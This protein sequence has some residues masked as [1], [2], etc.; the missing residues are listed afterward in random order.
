[1]TAGA[2][3]DGKDWSFDTL[4]RIYDAVEVVARDELAL[5]TFPNQIEVITAEQMLDAY[6]S[7]GMPLLYGI[8]LS[9]SV[10]PSMK[11][12]IAPASRALPMKSLST[13]TPASA[14]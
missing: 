12:S 11:A 9:A 10:S 7:T 14:M 8:G 4:Q 5:D 3:F 6:S 13:P 1:M 2:L